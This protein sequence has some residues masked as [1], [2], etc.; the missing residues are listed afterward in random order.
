MAND[1]GWLLRRREAVASQLRRIDD[2]LLDAFGKTARDAVRPWRR[3]PLTK[4]RPRPDVEVVKGISDGS[5]RPARAPEPPKR[6]HPA[7]A[8]ELRPDRVRAWAEKQQQLVD[9]PPPKKKRGRPPGSENANAWSPPPEKAGRP[10]PNPRELYERALREGKTT[11]AEV[12]E[13]IRATELNVVQLTE[14]L[15]AAGVEI[16]G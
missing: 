10:A 1:L 6:L 8:N 12:E 15:R 13:M 5:A 3:K 11:K 9:E 14:R 2:E 4:G 16:H 7:T